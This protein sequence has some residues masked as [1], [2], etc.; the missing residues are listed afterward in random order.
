M[1]V[2]PRELERRILLAMLGAAAIAVPTVACRKEPVPAPIVEADASARSKLCANPIEKEDEMCLEPFAAHPRSKGTGEPAPAP[3]RSAYDADG[4]LPKEMV[5]TGCC[6]PGL[7]GPRR[8]DGKCCY[9]V[10]TGVCCG[11]PFLVEGQP[12][13]ADVAFESSSAW[14]VGPEPMPMLD[15]ATARALGEAWLRDARMEHASTAAFGRF[16]LQLLALGGPAD[17]V[18]RAAL[19]AADEVRHAELCFTL[20]A[21]YLGASPSPA[22]LALDGAL[23]HA[24]ALPSIVADVIVEGCIGETIAALIAARQLEGA[25]DEKVAAALARIAEDEAR[26]A[27]LA[28]AFVRWALEVGGDETRAAARDTF[29]RAAAT[30]FSVPGDPGPIDPALWRSH[31]RLTRVETARVMEEAMSSVVAPCAAALLATSRS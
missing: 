13:I 15:E 17:L 27:E 3:A 11:R 4:C 22:P 14:V 12:R 24:R 1:L 21:R 7:D 26:H 29:D 8:K 18:R 25:R 19:A 31:G 28:W 30:G 2:T 5:S 10:C 6:N 9:T 23:D 20:A 16:M